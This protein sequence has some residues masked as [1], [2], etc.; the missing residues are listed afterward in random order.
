MLTVPEVGEAS[1]PRTWNSVDL[2]EPEGPTMLTKSPLATWR[3]TPRSAGD[4]HVA[5]AVDFAEVLN[6]NNR[7]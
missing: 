4:F 7:L 2:P 6:A 1:P 5:D 3:E